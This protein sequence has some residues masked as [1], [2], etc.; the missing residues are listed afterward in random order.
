MIISTQK[1][2][3]DFRQVQLLSHTSPVY[4]TEQGELSY[5]LMRYE[6]FQKMNHTQNSWANLAM[7]DEELETVGDFEVQRDVSL[8]TREVDL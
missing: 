4:I 8:Q 7:S 6:D 1:A 3:Q 2:I 5:V